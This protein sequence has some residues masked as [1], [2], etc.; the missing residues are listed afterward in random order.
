M[1]DYVFLHDVA[2]DFDAWVSASFPLPARGGRSAVRVAVPES[3]LNRA[4]KFEEHC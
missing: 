1:K 2:L 4:I 3:V